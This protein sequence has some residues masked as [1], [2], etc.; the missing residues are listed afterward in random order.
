MEPITDWARLWRQIVVARRTRWSDSGGP[1]ASDT[2]A[3]RA[4]EFNAHVRRRWQEAST[5][6]TV[7][8]AQ[9]DERATVLDVG[10]GTGR[11]AIPLARRAATVTALEPSPAMREGLRR[12]LAEQQI[13][14]VTVLAGRWPEAEV[15]PHDVVLCA[16]AMYGAEDLVAFVERLVDAARR[17]CTLLLRAPSRDSLMAQAAQIVWGHPHF[18][19]DFTVAYNVL[20]DMGLHPDVTMEQGTRW[21]ADASESLEEALA[22]VK[23]RLAVPAADDRYDADLDDLLRRRLV[24]AQGRLSWP[25]TLRSALVTWSTAEQPLPAVAAAPG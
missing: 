14:N 23:D 3:K 16:H 19:P 4:P 17:R 18:A 5:I 1:G 21:R 25:G 12:N 10:A 24:P 22:D 15:E 13:S 11:W 2:W 6:S 9:V 7:L 8:L 20:L